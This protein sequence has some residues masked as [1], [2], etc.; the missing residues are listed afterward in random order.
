M[1]TKS[2]ISQAYERV[3]LSALHSMLV[4]ALELFEKYKTWPM[5]LVLNPEF[6]RMNTKSPKFSSCLKYH[7]QIVVLGY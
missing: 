5:G 2:F 6:E 4:V 3:V 1:T 7:M